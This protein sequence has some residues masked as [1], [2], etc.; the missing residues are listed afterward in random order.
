VAEVAPRSVQLWSH[1]HR[2]S[3]TAVV[4]VEVTYTRT[5]YSKAGGYWSALTKRVHL[6]RAIGHFFVTRI[7]Y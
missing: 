3:R 6:E 7:F 4:F 1:Q 2:M 5:T